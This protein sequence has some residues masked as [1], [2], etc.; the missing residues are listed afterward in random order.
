MNGENEHYFEEYGRKKNTVFKAILEYTNNVE[1]VQ[2][3]D[4]YENVNVNEAIRVAK[5]SDIVILAIGEDT[6]AE[7]FGNVD[8]L[9]IS[10]VQQAFADALF[11]LSKPVVVIYVGGRPRV[12]SEI[13]ERAHAV[14]IAFLPG[15]S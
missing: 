14:L 13:V 3:V 6:Y 5:Q 12:I 9:A 8:S 10:Q 15:L 2:G 11:E 1:Y 4:F 7:G